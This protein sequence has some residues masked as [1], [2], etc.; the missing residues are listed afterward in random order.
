M[1][2]S[3]FP[4]SCAMF[5]M[6]KVVCQGFCG[7]C[8]RGVVGCAA[9]IAQIFPIYIILNIGQ[10]WLYTVFFCVPSCIEAHAEFQHFSVEK[11]CCWA[12]MEGSDL[13][14]VWPGHNLP[15]TGGQRTTGHG[16][17]F[18]LVS[19]SQFD[20]AVNNLLI[21]FTK[22]TCRELKSWCTRQ[23]IEA[24]KTLNLSNV[25]YQ[26]VWPIYW[27]WRIYQCSIFQRTTV[28]WE[29]ELSNCK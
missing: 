10:A 18:A 2:K 1:A 27:K 4:Q 9:P 3:Q 28:L 12:S 16:N 22:G 26:L 19:N 8:P 11:H 7:G 14:Q 17:H 21:A 15:S 6:T 24:V 25:T 20:I 23:I 13:R 29:V 5:S